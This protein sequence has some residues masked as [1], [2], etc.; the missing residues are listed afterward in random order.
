MSLPTVLPW[1][2]RQNRSYP[3]VEKR[4]AEIYAIL[5]A[6]DLDPD[7][8]PAWFPGGNSDK[9]EYARDRARQELRDA[10][11]VPVQQSDVPT[12]PDYPARQAS[13]CRLLQSYG[14][15][16]RDYRLLF[17]G[18]ATQIKGGR[19]TGV[20]WYDDANHVLSMLRQ[21]HD[22]LDDGKFYRWLGFVQGFLW[23]LKLRTID[24]MKDDNRG[25]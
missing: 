4:A 8:K 13:R 17:S 10:G 5:A 1:D 2:H 6:N 22:I 18:H 11:H 25:L 12:V 15:I 16:L 20:Q 3:P 14:V 23:S 19:P 21:M 9:Q 7:P 24:E